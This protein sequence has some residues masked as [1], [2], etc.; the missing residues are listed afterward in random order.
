[1]MLKNKLKTVWQR[2][3]YIF[4]RPA[5]IVYD[6]IEMLT[7]YFINFKKQAQYVWQTFLY[8]YL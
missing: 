3:K 8:T 2:S 4:V 5:E 7:N 6:L 1:M